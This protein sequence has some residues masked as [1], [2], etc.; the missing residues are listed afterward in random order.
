[1]RD[2]FGRLIVEGDD[3]IGAK[4]SLDHI[5]GVEHREM[6]DEFDTGVASANAFPQDA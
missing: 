3:G 4:V 6:L 5:K 2:L 1:M